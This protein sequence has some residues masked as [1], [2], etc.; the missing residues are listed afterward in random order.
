[1]ATLSHR[2]DDAFVYAHHIHGAQ[3]RK[4][5]KIPYISHLISVAALT[6]EHGGN[7]DQA[8]AALLHD[9]VEDC[10]GAP[11]LEIIRQ[12]FGDNVAQIVDDCTDSWVEPKPPWKQRKVDY[13]ASIAKKP[14]TSLLVSLADKTHNARCILLDLRTLGPQLWDRF[15]AEKDELLWYY[16]SLADASAEAIPCPLVQEMDRT[17]QEM[18][19]AG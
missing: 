18:K 11:Q 7:E 10:G 4:G 3:M 8:I 1:M 16:R 2:F 14:R 5:T 17:V 13:V 15:N 19:K 9:A 6:L 12:R